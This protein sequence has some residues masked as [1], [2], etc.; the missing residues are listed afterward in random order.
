MKIIE[1]NNSNQLDIFVAEKLGWVNIVNNQSAHFNRPLGQHQ[2]FSD[3]RRI[4]IPKYSTNTDAALELIEFVSKQIGVKSVNVSCTKGV[5]SSSIEI[6]NMYIEGHI[7]AHVE[8]EPTLALTICKTFYSY[9]QYIEK[10]VV[11]SFIME[12]IG[13]MS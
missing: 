4:S 3:D 7:I 5:Y 11:K 9:W 2:I 1:L 6:E 12:D 13:K 8:S 10:Q